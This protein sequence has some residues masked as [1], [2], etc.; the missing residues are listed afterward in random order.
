MVIQT[1]LQLSPPQVF[2]PAKEQL[3]ACSLPIPTPSISAMFTSMKNL[4]YMSANLAALSMPHPT[5]A[6]DSVSL[7]EQ[8]L[9]FAPPMTH[10]VENHDFDIGEALQSVGDA[11]SGLAAE[12]GIDLV[13]FHGDI[14]MRHAA[15][16]GDES[17]ISYTLS[18]VSHSSF[19]FA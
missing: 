11:L 3:S 13:L 15:V 10:S 7:A 1:L 9:P 17:G 16:K 8:P 12:S 4:N 5:Y 14:A 18:H 2:D 19:V 6:R